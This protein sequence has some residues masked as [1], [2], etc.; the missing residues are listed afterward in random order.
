V[1]VTRRQILVGGG[2]LGVSL[3][4]AAWKRDEIWGQEDGEPNSNAPFPLRIAS[5]ENLWCG[6]TLYGIDKGLFRQAGIAIQPT[7]TP[8]G[9]LN[10]E[11]LV[12]GSVEAANVVEV[13]IANQAIA[14]NR[15]LYVGA[16]IVHAADYGI[17][18]S[19]DRI[20]S[21]P[22]S[23]EGKSIAYAPGTGAEPY[24]FAL[25]EKLGLQ[26]VQ[27]KP[28][29]PTG[30]VDQVLNG[31]VDAAATWEPFVS[32]IA[33]KLP[34]PVVLRPAD[35]Y[36]GTMNLAFR[37]DWAEANSSKV[38]RVLEVYQ[39]AQAMVVS[40]Q[41][42]LIAILSQRMKIAPEKI[43][44]MLDRV[45]YALGLDA[46]IN[47]NLVKDVKRGI[48]QREPGRAASAVDPAIYY[49]GLK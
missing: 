24:I 15:N 32:T 37:R 10:M 29:P 21:D 8:A 22:K 38:S 31:G 5:S 35:I 46:A 18:G 11:A 16:S 7:F 2:I 20:G 4:V 19:A 47:L 3:G 44:P 28:I 41:P 45:D 36:T 33:G 42:G 23:L 14:G 6:L 26:R 1:T 30:I 43:A 17:V 39:K 40:D 34:R 13:N 25:I 48:I 9:R 27:L 12:S 49:S